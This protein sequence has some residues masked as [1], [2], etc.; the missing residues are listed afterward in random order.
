MVLFLFI[1]GRSKRIAKLFGVRLNLDLIENNLKNKNIKC[2]IISI[3]SKVIIFH[4]NK[5]NN[6]KI[7]KYLFE[8]FKIIKTNVE[9]KHIK[10]IPKTKN[11]KINYNE[12]EKKLI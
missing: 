8:E 5:T 11:N 2:A 10:Q 6:K 4:T 3:K 7:L 9:F 12:L 1:T